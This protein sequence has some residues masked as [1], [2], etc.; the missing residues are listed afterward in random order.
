MAGAAL[1]VGLAAGLLVDLELGFGAGLP[2]CF[3]AGLA[4][5]LAG[6][7]FSGLAGVLGLA[8]GLAALAGVC[9]PTAALLR[10]GAFLAGLL[11]TSTS[12]LA[13]DFIPASDARLWI[14][15]S[16]RARGL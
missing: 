7:F 6:L 9:F 12:L 11:L 8:A 13:G 16:I 1:A 15:A 3:A 5:R 4:L 2:A 14:P 10:A